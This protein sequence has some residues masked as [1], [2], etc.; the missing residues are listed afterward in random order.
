MTKLHLLSWGQGEIL[1]KN[2]NACWN[3]GIRKR[4]VT[5]NISKIIVYRLQTVTFAEIGELVQGIRFSLH[6]NDPSSL[7]ALLEMTYYK[8]TELALTITKHNP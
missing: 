8:E 3:L 4:K 6:V 7:P 5:N 2:L 1:H